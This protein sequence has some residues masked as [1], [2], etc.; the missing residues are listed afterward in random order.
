[1]MKILLLLLLVGYVTANSP[2]AVLQSA[3]D[4]ILQHFVLGM[5]DSSP[6]HR[7]L[8]V[9]QDDDVQ[10]L[11]NDIKE[12]LARHLRDVFEKAFKK[13]EEAMKDG[14]KIN[15]EALEKLHELR[16]KMKELNIDDDEVTEK[17]LEQLKEQVSET[18]RKILEKMGILDKR[19]LED[20][21]DA[22]FGELNLRALFIKLKNM[23]LEHL[24]V[25]SIKEALA[26]I[27]GQ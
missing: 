23:I 3:T 20:P 2:D 15:T 8:G 22:V 19:S 1:M 27:V 14:R 24:N 21:M 9:E 7:V 4:D 26:K 18:L 12:E 5:E 6:L 17:N 10:R 16:K 13:V 11:E 25:K